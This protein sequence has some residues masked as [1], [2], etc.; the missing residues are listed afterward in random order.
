VL[1]RSDLAHG[2]LARV[3]PGLADELRF[4]EQVMAR[5]GHPVKAVA[6]CFCMP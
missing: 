4:I 1:A 5:G 6:H 3:A 2:L